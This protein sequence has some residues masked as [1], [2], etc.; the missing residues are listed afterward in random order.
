M[1]AI[2]IQLPNLKILQENDPEVRVEKGK[3]YV[4]EENGILMKRRKDGNQAIILPKILREQA[5]KEAHSLGHHGFK[6]ALETMKKNFH[7][8]DM[9]NDLK[10]YVDACTTCQEFNPSRRVVAEALNL[11][12]R[13]L[14]TDFTIDFMGPFEILNTKVYVMV[15]VDMFTK[16]TYAKAMLDTTSHSVIEVLRELFSLFGAPRTILS[17]NGS[18]LIS[19]EIQYSIADGA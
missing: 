8:K 2:R 5:M 11:E 14:W 16:F 15:V 3:Q 9:G 19:E 6:K 18:N 17:D 7:W 1:N 4:M 12:A 10:E 13:G